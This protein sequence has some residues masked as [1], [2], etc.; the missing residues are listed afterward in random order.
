MQRPDEVSSSNEHLG[1][2]RGLTQSVSSGLATLRM[3]TPEVMENFSE[4]D[5]ALP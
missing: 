4:S 1:K 5:F 2:F 3:N